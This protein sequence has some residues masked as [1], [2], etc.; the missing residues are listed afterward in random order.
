M[1]TRLFSMRRLS[2]LVTTFFLSFL[3]IT[4]CSKDDNNNG[5]NDQMYTTQGDA[6]GGQQNPPV[7]TTGNARL[8]GTYN[9]TTN[10]WD[11]SIDWSALAGSATLIE[12]HGPADLGVNGAILF[13]VGVNAGGVNGAAS[14]STTLTEEQEGYLLANKIYY[15]ILTTAH[16]TGEVRG[17]VYTVTR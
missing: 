8:V 11:Y 14:A 4:A 2:L 7:T 16:I 17:Q 9:A 6:F 13:S 10:K 3:F 15:T 1:K 5:G 12:F